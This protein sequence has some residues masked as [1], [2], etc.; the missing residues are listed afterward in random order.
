VARAKAEV[1]PA[2]KP[3]SKPST[4]ARRSKSTYKPPK[5][6]KPAVF[7]DE[8]GAKICKTI[9]ELAITAPAAAAELGVA[10]QTLANW[11]AAGEAGDPRY[12]PFVG[13]LTRARAAAE[14]KLARKAM[15]GGKGSAMA[16]WLLERRFHKD[17][18]RRE[19]LDVSGDESQ[20]LVIRAVQQLVNISVK[21]VASPELSRSLDDALTDLGPTPPAITSE[22]VLP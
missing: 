17:Y 9:S 14:A 13:E 7:T 2:S 1:A 20:P 19:R 6:R 11:I 4:R 10:P 3:H 21:V 18:G 15:A 16:A 12:A 22:R 5:L 8:L